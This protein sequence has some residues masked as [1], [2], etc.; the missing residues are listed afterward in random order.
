MSEELL[1]VIML[2][3][4][5]V[6][7]AC[8][9]RA[10]YVKAPP[11]VAYIIS[12]M[13]KNPRILVGRA[14]IKL[15]FLERLD[16]L[17]LGQMSVDIRTEQSVPTNDYINVNVDAVAKVKLMSDPDNIKIASQ[18]FLNMS[19]KEITQQLVD[20]LQGN[21]REIIGTMSLEA[22]NTDRDKFSDEV[23]KKAS[24]DMNKLG[25]EVISCNIQNVVDDNGIIVDLGADNI[26]Q[27]KKKAAIAKAQAE[28][29][30]A[31]A[32][33]EAAKESND[34]RVLSESQM[35]EKNNELEVRKA[36]L[37]KISDIKKAE[38]DAAY[39]I[40]N[41]EQ[42]KIIETTTMNASIAKTEREAELKEKEITIKEKS[43]EASIKKQA[44][45]EKYRTEQQAAADLER[46]KRD[47]EAAMYEEQ[48]KAEALKAQAEANKY[49]MEQEAAGIRAKAE[50]EAEGLRLRGEA[51][52]TAIQ[53]K[54]LAE[55][56]A[57]QKKAE[58]YKLYN[59]AAMAEM[60]IKVMPQIAGEIAKPLAS[61]DKVSVI[62][63]GAEGVSSIGD[64]VPV[65]M[66]KLF[67]TMK[68]TTGVDLGDIMK[69]NSIQAK[70][71]RNINI[72]GLD[73]V[74]IVQTTEE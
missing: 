34:A 74:E 72:K 25:V 4:L 10:S 42:R 70:T 26:S 7:L 8:L 54:G 30:V 3:V 19:V 47:A 12:G 48:R 18:N 46:R 73:N 71:D 33:S 5:L 64:G 55:A 35:A 61:I 56:E 21:L 58:A 22:V 24:V 32:R 68:E 59:S 16:H 28:R 65:M 66:A 2:V 29:D 11:N 57:M 6:M 50:A 49:M 52:A 9:L 67:Q 39:E 31:I 15:P 20:S 62:G 38:A 45:A 60:V 37:K 36:E 51:E 13:G 17:Y 27:I 69:S 43:L 40:Q 14:G 1:L 53:A 41:Q 44:D 63:N 23:M